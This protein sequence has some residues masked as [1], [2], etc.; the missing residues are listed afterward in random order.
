MHKYDKPVQQPLF[1]HLPNRV[2]AEYLALQDL[3]NLFKLLPTLPSGKRKDSLST[4]IQNGLEDADLFRLATQTSSEKEKKLQFT[5]DERNAEV[6]Q[7]KRMVESL[8]QQVLDS[9]RPQ[10]L[11]PWWAVVT[12]FAVLLVMILF[13]PT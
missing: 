5:L 7:L 9:H 3:A 2:R 6:T 13:K 4:L 8:E 11:F 1:E 10:Y 12:S